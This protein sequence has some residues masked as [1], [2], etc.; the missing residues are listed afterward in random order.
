MKNKK[1]II[2]L[3]IIILILS[4]IGYIIWDNVEISKNEQ[5][6]IEYTPKEEI[7]R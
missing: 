5:E 1:I 2:I 7:T 4:I 3:V 6:I